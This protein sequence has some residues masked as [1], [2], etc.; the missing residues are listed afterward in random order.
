[1]EIHQLTFLVTDDDLNALAQKFLIPK[2]PLEGLKMEILP[3]GVKISGE[4]PLIM[5]IPFKMMWELTCR[6]GILLARLKKLQA[7]GMSMSIFKNIFLKVLEELGKKAAGLTYKDDTASLRLEE[8][9]REEGLNL[10][11]GLQEIHC[12]KGIMTVKASC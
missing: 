4:Y 8:W 10:K 9:A 2:Y 1:M 11:I 12:Q 7:M 5:P 3:N 6:E